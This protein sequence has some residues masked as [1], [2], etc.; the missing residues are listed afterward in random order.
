MGIP[1]DQVYDLTLFVNRVVVAARLL[2]SSVELLVWIARETELRREAR[3]SEVLRIK[4]GGKRLRVCIL[5]R[6]EGPGA[7]LLDA[8]K[9]QNAEY[10]I[11][12]KIAVLEG[13]VAVEGDRLV[14]CQTIPTTSTFEGRIKKRGQ[15]AARGVSH[16]TR[17]DAYTMVPVGLHR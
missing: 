17:T 10:N 7:I 11:D 16:E 15:F 9:R 8:V 6:E 14:V 2:P 12:E 5:G 13:R 4:T 1:V 3:R